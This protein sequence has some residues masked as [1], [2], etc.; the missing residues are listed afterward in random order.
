M[1]QSEVFKGFK[2]H[3]KAYKGYKEPTRKDL[4]LLHSKLKDLVLEAKRVLQYKKGI[5]GYYITPFISD[6]IELAFN[7][8]C[9]AE[10]LFNK[11]FKDLSNI[12]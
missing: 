4:E 2:G 8:L 3:Y 12:N 11:D 1:N 10:E 7:Y 5:H 6:E 9:E